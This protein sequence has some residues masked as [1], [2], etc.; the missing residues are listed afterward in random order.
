[1]PIL[2]KLRSHLRRHDDAQHNM[3]QHEN[4]NL[5]LQSISDVTKEHRTHD[6]FV[7]DSQAQTTH[8]AREA[9]LSEASDELESCETFS[10]TSRRKKVV[11]PVGDIMETSQTDAK[12]EDKSFFPIG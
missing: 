7:V 5:A 6:K 12:D 1:M 4:D 8:T 10:K 11:Q 3:F 9:T 2:P